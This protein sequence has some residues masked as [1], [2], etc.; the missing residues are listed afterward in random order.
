MY[1]AVN[2]SEILCLPSALAIWAKGVRLLSKH[3]PLSWLSQLIGRSPLIVVRGERIFWP[4]CPADLSSD[5]GKMAVLAHELT[6]VWQYRHGMRWWRYLMRERGHY[7]YRLIEGKAFLDYG[8]EQQA[9]MVED[10]IRLGFGLKLR[11][12]YSGTDVVGLMKILPFN[13]D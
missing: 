12:G 2:E 1:R 13:L 9:A 7:H 6:H 5:K 4:D 3:H 11:W 8:Y 10:A